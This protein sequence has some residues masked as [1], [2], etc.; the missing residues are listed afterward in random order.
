MTDRTGDS[1]KSAHE[2]KS[3]SEQQDEDYDKMQTEN[4]KSTRTPDRPTAS[5]E[6]DSARASRSRDAEKSTDGQPAGLQQRSGAHQPHALSAALAQA[7]NTVQT[8]IS[9]AQQS[10]S[11]A[12][13]MQ[14]A[15]APPTLMFHQQQSFHPPPG[16]HQNQYPMQGSSS[17]ADYSQILAAYQPAASG[18]PIGFGGNP[19][20]GFPSHP[21]GPCNSTSVLTA[22]L[23]GAVGMGGYNESNASTTEANETWRILDNHPHLLDPDVKPTHSDGQPCIQGAAMFSSQTI[24]P[25]LVF[26]GQKDTGRWCEAREAVT[27]LI[28][29]ST[30][31][32]EYTLDDVRNSVASD[33]ERLKGFDDACI[34]E[35]LPASMGRN[36]PYRVTMAAA[37]ALSLIEAEGVNLFHFDSANG[38]ENELDFD[39]ELLLPSGRKYTLARPDLPPRQPKKHDTSCRIRFQMTIP[40]ALSA[41]SA[42]EREKAMTRLRD[43]LRHHFLGHSAHNV[44]FHKHRDERSGRNAQ[45]LIGFVNHPVTVSRAEF[46]ATAF[47]DL[48]YVNAGMGELV[49][50]TLDH[51]YTV[52]ASIMKCC[53]RAVCLKQQGGKCEAW[54]QMMR[55]HGLFN[56]PAGPYLARGKRKFELT[57][58]QEEYRVSQTSAIK[59]MRLEKECRAHT[60]GRCVNGSA[61]RAPHITDPATILCNSIVTPADKGVSSFNRS[62]GFCALHQKQM[63]C[64]YKD[65][66]HKLDYDGPQTS[67]VHDPPRR[68]RGWRRDRLA[69]S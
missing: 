36:G 40:V 59:A 35:E 61:C 64:P 24:A 7:A 49:K 4:T 23:S 37:A 16:G 9:Q 57:S 60:R 43:L 66:V 28:V 17:D 47:Q 68:A 51:D 65:C 21:M 67:G 63:A 39:V 13:A 44:G 38:I 2:A 58:Q 53:F 42:E 15:M 34:L 31:E 10:I 5:G 20:S 30:S 25:G 52:K 26:L 29:N 1:T 55:R 27:L 50:L 14:H 8:T 3:V 62:Y 56:Q 19:L 33:I 54:V 18:T 12:N 32:F 41:R 46:I 69:V 45:G 6:V 22:P 48:K 11:M